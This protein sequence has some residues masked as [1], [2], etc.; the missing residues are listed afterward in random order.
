MTSGTSN[1]IQK[2]PANLYEQMGE[3]GAMIA[4]AQMLGFKLNAPDSPIAEGFR[5]ILREIPALNEQDPQMGALLHAFL[6]HLQ[7]ELNRLR[8]E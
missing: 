3:G 2:M 5:M 1:G 6:E 4:L 8:K 7:T